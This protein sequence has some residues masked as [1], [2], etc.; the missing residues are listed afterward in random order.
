[1][2]EAGPLPGPCGTSTITAYTP[3]SEKMSARVF[4][5]EVR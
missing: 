5:G 1:V 3:N 4:V 2:R